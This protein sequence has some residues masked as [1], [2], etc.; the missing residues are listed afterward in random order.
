[1]RILGKSAMLG[2]GATVSRAMDEH[3]DTY[4]SEWELIEPAVA[5]EARRLAE[6]TDS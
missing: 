4:T 5:I 1:M 2:Y 6:E 3:L